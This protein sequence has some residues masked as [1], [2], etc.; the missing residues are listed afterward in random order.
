MLR[1]IS[2]GYKYGQR[3]QADRLFDCRSLSNPHNDRQL[4]EL[5]GKDAAVQ[6][7]VKADP[8]AVDM[9]ARASSG[10]APG[11][12]IAFGCFGGRHRSVSLV[13]MLAAAALKAG[14]AVEIS[15]T[16]LGET[17]SLSPFFPSPSA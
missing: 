11:Q 10:L 5:T 2:F 6:A 15:H 8:K 12:T 7:F 4:R 14:V 17:R 3:P 1:L 13:E 9:L 16:A